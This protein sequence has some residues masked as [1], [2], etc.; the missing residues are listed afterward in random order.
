MRAATAHARAGG[1]AGIHPVHVAPGPAGHAAWPR[2]GQEGWVHAV[3]PW[4]PCAGWLRWRVARCAG[5]GPGRVSIK[6]DPAEGRAWS[7]EQAAQARAA[8]KRGRQKQRQ[9]RPAL[10]GGSLG[11]QASNGRG[12]GIGSK[13]C[14]TAAPGVPR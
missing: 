3:R 13:S 1:W 6:L 8:G 2:R 4:R 5:W 11:K 9:T 14:K 12:K 10:L 7:M